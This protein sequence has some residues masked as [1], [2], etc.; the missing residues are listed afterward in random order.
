M[1]MSDQKFEN[2]DLMEQKMPNV[3]E[4][5]RDLI[6]RIAEKEAQLNETSKNRD[7]YLRKLF[8]DI[9]QVCDSFENLFEF[10]ET[11]KEELSPDT[12]RVMN[13]FKTIH[14]LLQKVLK[15][16]Q[17]LVIKTESS[18]FDPHWQQILETVQDPTKEDG[19][20]VEEINKGY[21]WQDYVL[22]EAKVK[23]VKNESDGSL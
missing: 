1:I 22:R 16:R 15:D 10:L 4:K 2:K 3:E 8:L 21:I 11:K 23:V 5:I 14:R 12:M 19:F 20:V 13:N 6:H 7:Q 9:I 18:Y 17:V